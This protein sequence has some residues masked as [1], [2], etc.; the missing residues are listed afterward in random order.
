MRLI[1]MLALLTS[2]ASNKYSQETL[3][4]AKKI[5]KE[6][7]T[8]DTHVDIDTSYFSKDKNLGMKTPNQVDLP[9]MREGGLDAA[10]FIVYTAQHTRDQDGYAM[11]YNRAKE[12][13]NAIHRMTDDFNKDEILLVRQYSDI[14]KARKSNKLIAM[15]GVENAFPIGT[16]LKRVD[17]FYRL[18]ARYMSLTHNG[19]SQFADSNVMNKKFDKKEEKYG[20]VSP[21]GIKL[22]KKLNK[23]GI[24]VD[25][26]HSSKKAMLDIIKYSKAP[27]IASHS[28]AR[29]IYDHPRNIDD[30]QLLALKKNKGVIQVV[31]FQSYLKEPPKEK[32]IARKNLDKEFGLPDDMT[33]YFILRTKPKEKQNEYWNRVEQISNK[34]PHAFVED[35]VDHIDHVVEVAGIDHVGISSDFGGGGG[36]FGW[37]DASET[38]NITNELVHRGYSKEE[39]RKIWSANLLRVYKEVEQIAKSN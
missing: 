31:A 5:H 1:L 29:N 6:V 35:L 2:C 17:E 24:M 7:I 9:K 3:E 32:T 16:D 38:L 18:G 28:G 23:L 11:A 26:S 25:V 33:K 37:M 34:Y 30:E 4:K 39:I 22:I 8:L 12:M 14:K 15:I 27:V 21:L 19:H 13:F 10:F 20:G 36:I